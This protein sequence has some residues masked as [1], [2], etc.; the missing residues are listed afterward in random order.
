MTRDASVLSGKLVSI[1][2]DAA[3]SIAEGIRVGML[4]KRER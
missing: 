1:V 2:D 4:K 3:A